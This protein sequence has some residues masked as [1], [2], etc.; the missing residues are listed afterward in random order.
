MND[1]QHQGKR[2]LDQTSPLHF[3]LMFFH[4]RMSSA[5]LHSVLFYCNCVKIPYATLYAFMYLCIKYLLFVNLCNC[6]LL[7]L[8]SFFLRFVKMF[9]VSTYTVYSHLNLIVYARSKNKLRKRDQR[10]FYL[11]VLMILTLT[12]IQS[13]TNIPTKISLHIELHSNKDTLLVIVFALE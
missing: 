3:F 13:S 12:K 11:L 7:T 5:F 4:V 6:I 1:N 2:D 8:A 9:F 10:A